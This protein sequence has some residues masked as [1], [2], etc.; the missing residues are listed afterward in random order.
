ML[1]NMKPPALIILLGFTCC[2]VGCSV[3]PNYDRG[4]I[5]SAQL[6]P[7][8]WRWQKADPRDAAPRGDW[9]TLY[10]DPEL[11]RLE[12]I[13]RIKNQDLRSAIA[14]V[15]KARAQARISGAA[16]FP[17]ISL[18][19]EVNRERLSGNNPEFTQFG[20]VV[21]PATV[22]SFNVPVDLSYEIDLWGRVRR[23]YESARDSAQAAVADVENVLLTLQADVAIDYFTLREYDT[24]LKI[25]RETV[26]SRKKSLEIAQKRLQGGRA[27]ELDVE[28]AKTELANSE[29]DLADVAQNRAETQNALAVLCGEAA[30]D[31]TVE[32]VPLAIDT[33][34]PEIPIGLPASLLERRPDVAQAERNMAA[35]NAQIGVAY[36]AYFPTVSL[37]G[38]YGY[39]SARASDL[40]AKPSNMWS[41]GPSV[42]LPIFTGG[43]TTAKVKSA[44]ADYD[45]AV[46]DYRNSV[47]GAFRD[48]EDSLARRHFLAER[49][50]A[51]GRAVEAAHKALELSEKRYR[52]G[53]IGYFE[54]TQSQRT[55]LV[56]E[57]SQAQVAG[58]RLYASI[59]LIK[60]LGGGWNAAQLQ[61]E[62]PAPY[63]VAP[64]GSSATLPVGANEAAQGVTKTP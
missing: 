18:D 30:S 45:A 57:R 37:T 42:S 63:P 13:S 12:N 61:M 14:R 38:Q 59:R 25:L 17:H 40:F 23:S 8:D 22:N 20:L 48:V 5:D 54:V 43:E 55:E 39:F 27:T 32:E 56:A 7:A 11:T 19:P 28:Q 6:P 64:L 49:A 21:P 58:L 4:S 29:S 62:Q 53:T 24:E 41:F 36:A 50:E 2:I 16:F 60:A 9:W 52:S 44:R 10:S 1:T 15:D 26:G 51:L 35:R 47:L 46:A 3:G 34:P 31:F 33:V